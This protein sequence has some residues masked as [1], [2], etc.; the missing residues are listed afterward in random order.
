[1]ILSPTPRLHREGL[2]FSCQRG[3]SEEVT[4]RVSVILLRL[5]YKVILLLLLFL[6]GLRLVVIRLVVIRLAVILINSQ[7]VM[8]RILHR[9]TSLSGVE[10]VA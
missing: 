6:N 8:Q 9:R 5:T 4:R 7:I 1:M 2:V 10:Y 3:L